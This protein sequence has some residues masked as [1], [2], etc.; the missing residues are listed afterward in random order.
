M[1]NKSGLTFFLSIKCLSL[2]L[3]IALTVKGSLIHCYYNSA[4][5]IDTP[6]TKKIILF[7]CFVDCFVIILYKFSVYILWHKFVMSIHS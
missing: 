2:C 6:L 7:N 1:T 4:V 3:S 5:R